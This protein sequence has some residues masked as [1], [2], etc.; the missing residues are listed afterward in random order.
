MSKDG[1][2]SFESE[3]L[4]LVDSGDNEVGYL[5][6]DKCHDGDGVLHRAFSLFVFNTDGELLLQQRSAGK[7]LWPLFWS[8]SVCSHPRKGE[9]MEVATRRRLHEEL[10]IEAELEFVYKFPYQAQ[11]GEHGSENEL[12]SVYLGETGQSFSANTNEIAAARYISRE[13]L[14]NEVMTKPGQFTPWFRM[15][16]ER[17]CEEFAGKLAEY[18]K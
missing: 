7:R 14:E 4:I 12:C 13:A 17:L 1:I 3:E 8:N 11:F 10:D 9:T 6:K 15:E 2:V 5:S 18:A 16:W